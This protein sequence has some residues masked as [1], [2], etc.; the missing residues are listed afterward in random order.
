LICT[1]IILGWFVLVLNQASLEQQVLARDLRGQHLAT[2]EM[3]RG[4]NRNL[5][6]LG[7]FYDVKPKKDR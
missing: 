1:I 6:N 3:V 7:I 4:I 5:F 2:Q